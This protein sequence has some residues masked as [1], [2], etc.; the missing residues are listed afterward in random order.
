MIYITLTILGLT[1]GALSGMFGIGGGVFV[2]PALM[3]FYGFS[4]KMATGT[5]LAMLLPPIGILAFLEYYK[6]GFVDVRATVILV[7]GFL[8][9]SY[10]SAKFVIKMDELI[11]K[12]SFGILLIIIGIIYITQKK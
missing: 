10:F 3:F 6:N 9:G 4:Q 2:I 8:I 11:L 12:R 5:T 1:V 7:C